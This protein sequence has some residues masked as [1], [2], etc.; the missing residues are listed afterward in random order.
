M[1]K[2]C[3]IFKVI[4]WL[5]NDSKMGCFGQKSISMAFFVLSF[6]ANRKFVSHFV[7]EIFELKVGKSSLLVEYNTSSYILSFPLSSSSSSSSFFIYHAKLQ[8]V[9]GLI[10]L[11]LLVRYPQCY[12]FLESL[13]HFEFNQI[14]IFEMFSNA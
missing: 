5:Q 3:S 7:L 11:D 10:T 2:K 1:S 12:T 14:E 8:W 9:S 6:A 4:F 13:G